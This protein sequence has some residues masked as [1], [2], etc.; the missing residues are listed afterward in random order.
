MGFC[1]TCDLSGLSPS[2]SRNSRFWRM[3]SHSLS[4][5]SAKLKELHTSE[6]VFPTV[7]VSLSL[8][9]IFAVS[10]QLSILYFTL[11]VCALLLEQRHSLTPTEAILLLIAA[12]SQTEKEIKAVAANPKAVSG[13]LDEI[14]TPTQTVLLK[15]RFLHYSFIQT[16]QAVVI[17]LTRKVAGVARENTRASF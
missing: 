16:N 8:A 5:L 10:I 11:D 4:R 3:R 2:E 9:S 13:H 1:S 17:T 6:L 15:T 12:I 7:N 14:E